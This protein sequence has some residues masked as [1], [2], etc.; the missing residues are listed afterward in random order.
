MCYSHGW[1]L[2][3][4]KVVVVIAIVSVVV[5]VVVVLSIDSVIVF[6]LI[7]NAERQQQVGKPPAEKATDR[8]VTFR[9]AL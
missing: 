1:T 6:V 7:R 4:T 5:V 2:W 9:N 8:C 3:E